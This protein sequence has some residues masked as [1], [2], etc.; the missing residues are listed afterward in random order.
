MVRQDHT[1][2]MMALAEGS[3]FCRYCGMSENQIVR[4]R[5]ADEAEPPVK[6]RDPKL[7]PVYVSPMRRKRS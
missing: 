1:H 6:N 5:L 4:E 2:S 7:P 3:Y